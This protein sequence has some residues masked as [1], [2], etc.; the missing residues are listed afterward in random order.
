M[1]TVIGALLRNP[2]RNLST[3][4]KITLAKPQS[5]V[6]PNSLRVAVEV[7]LISYCLLQKRHK[8]SISAVNNKGISIVFCKV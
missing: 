1:G 4:L 3:D 8:I 5:W 7:E 6:T 2:A